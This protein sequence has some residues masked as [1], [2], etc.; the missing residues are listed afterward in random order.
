M[1]TLAS[2]IAGL[3]S[4]ETSAALK[5]AK[6]ASAVYL[7][8]GAAFL[9]GAGF[10]VGAL[11]VWTAGRYG[12]IRASL[13]F[14]AGFLVLGGL[15]LLAF[16]LTAGIRAKRRERERKADLTA[17]GVSAAAALLPTLARGRGGLGIIL[18]PAAA[19][20]AYMIYKE[21]ARRGRDGGGPGAGI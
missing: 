18:G 13:G 20:A 15:I 4:G 8:A 5:R 3:A 16:R 9:I 11:Y 6:L 10:L 19:L 14:G 21:N 17:V 12:P 2:L 1:G 7:C